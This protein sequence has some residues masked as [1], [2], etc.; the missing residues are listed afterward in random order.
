[1]SD[2]P[3]W[4]RIDPAERDRQLAQFCQEGLTALAIANKFVNCT[5]SAVIGRLHRLKLK[6]NNGEPR[7]SGPGRKPAAGGAVK[8]TALKAAPARRVSKLVQQT[9]SWRGANNPPATDFKARAERRAAS[10]GLPAHLVAGEARRPIEAAVPI[11]LNLKLVELTE[12]TCKWP[13]GDPQAADFGF[14]GNGAAETGPYCKYHARIAYTPPTYR[15]S[16]PKGA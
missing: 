9:S 1:M 2:L 5:R 10:P 11:S 3:D 8:S 12:H 13:V 4:K 6:L 14:C 7:P 16:V 15:L